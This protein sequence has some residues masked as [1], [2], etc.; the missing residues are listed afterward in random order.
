MGDKESDFMPKDEDTTDFSFNSEQVKVANGELE[1]ETSRLETRTIGA[2]LSIRQRAILLVAYEMYQAKEQG[3]DYLEMPLGEF[4]KDAA[5]LL[6]VDQQ[7][8]K[9]DIQLMGS[10]MCKTFL[11]GSKQKKVHW[12]SEEGARKYREYEQ[13]KAQLVLEAAQK[14]RKHG[15]VPKAL[16]VLAIPALVALLLSLIPSTVKAEGFGSGWG[17][18]FE[19]AQT[20]T[21]SSSTSMGHTSGGGLD[22]TFGTGYGQAH[23]LAQQALNGNYTGGIYSGGN[24]TGGLY[25]GQ[26]IIWADRTDFLDKY[27]PKVQY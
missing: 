25:T 4:E 23:Q 13:G 21:F 18:A 3:E 26:N 6:G 19:P 2:N 24:Y 12:I 5:G 22:S 20:H 11:K 8:I 9:T 27:R 14:I 10:L 1:N 17:G 16:K 7:T 15:D